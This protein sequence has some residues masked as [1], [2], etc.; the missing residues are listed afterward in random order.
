M[1]SD[2]YPATATPPAAFDDASEARLRDVVSFSKGMVHDLRN[3][4][5]VI[6]ANVYLMRQ[7]L[8]GSDPRSL[9]PVERVADQV[10]AVERLLNGYLAF[11]QADHP[12]FQRSQL[13][14]VVRGVAESLVLGEACRVELELEESLPLVDADP[15]LLESAL[16]ALIRN[17]VRAMGSE[18]TVRLSTGAV[19][20]GV[21]LRVEDTGPGIE[22]SLLPRVFEPFFS[23]WEEHAGLGLA[24]VAKV[25]RAH[26]G[27]C[28][29]C[30]GPGRG[31][32]VEMVLPR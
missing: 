5:N 20:E 1:A 19:P 25:A 26:G 14:D 21:R 13:N 27:G 32:C 29:L 30:T 10:K 24:L 6:V 7:R 2:R 22:E 23:T 15:G 17:A 4:L 28:R 12:V 31:T 11:E 16:R 8:A 9:R 3:P 18:G